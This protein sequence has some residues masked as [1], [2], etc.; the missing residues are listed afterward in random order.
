M[1]EGVRAYHHYLSNQP[2]VAITDN[3]ALKWLNNTKHTTP[4]LL[5][6]S[7]VLQGYNY[8]IHRPGTQNKNADALSHREYDCD[9]S[10]Q[11][12]IDE[13][14]LDETAILSIDPTTFLQL[15]TNPKKTSLLK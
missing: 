3:I 9:I 4:R 2:F 11:S 6:W 5:W 13:A 1:I 7:L 15:P 14:C 8:E 10:P 12:K